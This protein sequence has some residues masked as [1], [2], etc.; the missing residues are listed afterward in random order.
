MTRVFS[1]IIVLVAVLC[2]A[3]SRTEE[4]TLSVVPCTPIP[5][6]RASACATACDG[7]AYVF[8]GRDSA[9]K[10]RN[11]LWEY[12]VANNTWN[13]IKTPLKGRVH[14]SMIAVGKTIY[15]GLGFSGKIYEDS[16]YLR[17]WWR[18]TPASGKWEQLQDFVSQCTIGN[19]TYLVGNRIYAIYGADGCFSRHIHH[20]DIDKNEWTRE[21]ESHLRAKSGFGGVGAQVQDRY[22][23]GLGNNTSNL[24]QWFE[25]DLSTDKWTKRTDIPGKGRTLGACCA[26]NDYIYVFG[27]RCFA[28]EYTGGEVFCD[29]YRYDPQSDKWEHCG[30]MP[31]G[32][33]ENLVAFTLNGK[34]YFGLG[35]DTE[36]RLLKQLYRVE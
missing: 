16:C 30:Q 14:P 10:Y 12:D 5:E 35:E 3:C 19:T 27:G 1:Y 2:A 34:A 31:Y 24:T 6:G 21:E 36:G 22:F 33:A 4:V 25:V 23:Y 18:Y 11:E 29:Y 20:Y 28:G 17:D 15:L 26:T 8:G 9:G 13:C 7:K 32:T